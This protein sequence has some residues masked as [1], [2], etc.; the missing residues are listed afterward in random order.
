MSFSIDASGAA[1]VLDQVN[2]RVV[3]FEPGRPPHTIAL[4]ADTCQDIE[5]DLHGNTI[6]L[7][8]LSTAS[9]VLIDSQGNTKHSIPIVGDKIPEGGLVTGMFA[10]SDGLWLEVEH[11]ELV[12]IADAEGAP[13]PA[14]P[15][16][17][18]R[19]SGDGRSALLAGISG[20]TNIQLNASPI[21]SGG[22]SFSASIAFPARISGIH[23]LECDA[24]GRIFIAAS[25]LLEGPPPTFELLEAHTYV[26]ALSPNGRELGRIEI[27]PLISPL[28]QFR[29]I[30]VGPDGSIYELVP[31][32]DGVRIE[33]YTL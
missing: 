28:E 31:G 16:V 15:S 27:S 1:R 21:A 11:R 13:D 24:A 20:G 7:D 18:G 26:V 33:R 5:T 32:E 10:R 12:R 9:L 4:P 29:P 2:Q 19:F 8:R 22:I 30:R 25:T 3:L 6:V 17:P 23:A 14:R